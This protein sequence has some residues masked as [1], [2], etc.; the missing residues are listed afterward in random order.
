[1]IQLRKETDGLKEV[2][3]MVQDGGGKD[4]Q[5]RVVLVKEGGRDISE[6]NNIKQNACM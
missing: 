1:M 2:G 6:K 5:M 4:E 3:L